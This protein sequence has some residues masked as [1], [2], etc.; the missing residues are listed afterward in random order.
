MQIV[1]TFIRRERISFSMFSSLHET[2]GSKIPFSCA[3]VNVFFHSCLQTFSDLRASSA[4]GHAGAKLSRIGVTS[5]SCC[6]RHFDQKASHF[7]WIHE[8]CSKFDNI[9]E[10]KRNISFLFRMF[11][12]FGG[13]QWDLN[14][15][16]YNSPGNRRTLMIAKGQGETKQSLWIKFSFRTTRFSRFVQGIVPLLTI[17]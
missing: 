11:F 5:T 13:T 3:W 14:T 1:I 8:I 7:T 6:E 16:V 12:V 10:K 15:G 4:G 9:I 17:W 2:A